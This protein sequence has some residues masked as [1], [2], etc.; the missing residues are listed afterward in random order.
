VVLE[1]VP[2]V[3]NRRG[4]ETE[5]GDEPLN[6]CLPDGA[7]VEV[8]ES[9]GYQ[10]V[11]KG[12]RQRRPAVVVGVCGRGEG[13]VSIVVE[14]VVSAALGRL[15]REITRVGDLYVTTATASPLV[16]RLRPTVS[17]RVSR[18]DLLQP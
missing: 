12:V 2:R 18:A 8:D 9:D 3:V 14:C 11:L 5:G 6:R 15:S 1:G 7:E 16:D 10:L 13:E 4:R 17:S